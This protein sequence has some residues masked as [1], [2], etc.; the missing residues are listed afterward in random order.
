MSL[1]QRST[2]YGR[3]LRTSSW[4]ATSATTRRSTSNIR[5]GAETA[6]PTSR[7]ARARMSASHPGAGRRLQAQLPGICEQ[8]AEPPG[9]AHGA[10]AIRRAEASGESFGSFGR[11]SFHREEKTR[12]FEVYESDADRAREAFVFSEGARAVSA[13]EMNDAKSRATWPG[14]SHGEAGRRNPICIQQNVARWSERFIVV[15]TG[16]AS[17]T[18]GCMFRPRR[19]SW[20]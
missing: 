14:E 18:R 13:G 15:M 2:I 1:M 12:T 4:S 16:L 3:S 17:V 19:P 20:L 8:R 5:P 7:R 6:S 9:L 11:F 10:A